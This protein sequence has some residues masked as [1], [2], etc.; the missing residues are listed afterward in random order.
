LAQS[1]SN[2]I[3]TFGTFHI[4]FYLNVWHIPNQIL[5]ERLAHSTSNFIW[6]YIRKCVCSEMTLMLLM[7]VFRIGSS[8]YRRRHEDVEGR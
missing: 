2:F 7:L 4:K 3:W 6:T 1:T 5:F 8:V